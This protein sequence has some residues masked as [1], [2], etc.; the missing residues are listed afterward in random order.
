[1]KVQTLTPMRT[2]I[3]QAAGIGHRLEC[4]ACNG[5]G[6][7]APVLDAR[8]AIIVRVKLRIEREVVPAKADCLAQQ[9]GA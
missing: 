7:A 6:L 8:E 9:C 5:I 3:A 4:A 1:M 2:T